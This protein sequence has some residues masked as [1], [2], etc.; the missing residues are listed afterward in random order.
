[1]R[2]VKKTSVR[3]K[4]IAIMLLIAIIPL[5]VAVIISY[6]SST[7]KDIAEKLNKE[8]AFFK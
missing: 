5:T 1:M 6:L 3:S 2:K 8:I 7:S 4:L